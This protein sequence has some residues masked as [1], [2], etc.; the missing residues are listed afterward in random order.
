MPDGIK[1]KPNPE[2]IYFILE[3]LKVDSK[4][5][6]MVGDSTHDIEAG[7][8]AGIFTCAVSYGYRPLS[9]LKKSNPDFII[10]NVKELKNIINN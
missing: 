10:D 8:Q 3:Q 1:P 9:I 7:K 6:L 5:T 2:G 4:K